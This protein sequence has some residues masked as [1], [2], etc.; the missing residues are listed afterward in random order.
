MHHYSLS[1]ESHILQ[2]RLPRLDPKSTGTRRQ[3]SH[4][5]S[6]ISGWKALRKLSKTALSFVSLMYSTAL[7]SFKIRTVTL[8][9][10]AE[11][12]SS[13]SR[14][15][16]QDYTLP[17]LSS[18]AIRINWKGKKAF[19]F[20]LSFCWFTSALVGFF[21]ECFGFSLPDFLSCTVKKKKKKSIK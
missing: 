20:F 11:I 9:R 14:Q 1:K 4:C 6:L 3:P 21:F 7:I 15:E 8:G 17:A 16:R 2:D 19:I 10:E 13:A 5:L 12:V 18:K